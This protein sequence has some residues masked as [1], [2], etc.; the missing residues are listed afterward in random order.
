MI[1]ILRF[2][3]F[4]FLCFNSAYSQS[5]YFKT[6]KNFSNYVF[7]TSS[8][9]I[10]SS[11]VKLQTDSGSYYE[12]GAAIPFDNSRFSYEFGLSLNELNSIVEAPSNAVRYKTEFFGLNNSFNFSVIKSNR[13][14]WDAKLG[15]ELQSMVFG[16]QE[17]EGVLYDLKK[18]TEFN[19]LFFRQSF[20][21]QI[22]L[23]ATSQFN[24]SIGYDYYY[25]V[26][27]TKNSSNQS[28]LI[29]S[30]QVKFGIYYK[31]EKLKKDNKESLT[32]P[33]LESRDLNSS[34][35]ESMKDSEL[36]TI[37]S[38]NK[39]DIKQTSMPIRS[40]T[41][42]AIQNK[43]GVTQQNAV[44]NN[45]LKGSL[46][47]IN[48]SSR[49]TL[50][51]SDDNIVK[52]KRV[53]SSTGLKLAG[54]NTKANQSPMIVRPSSKSSVIPS[55]S[56]FV[57][58]INSNVSS[59]NFTSAPNSGDNIVKEKGVPL[60]TGLKLASTDT[61]S[62]SKSNDSSPLSKSS[63][64]T[65]KSSLVKPISSNVISNNPTPAK[66]ST[67]NLVEKSLSNSNSKI[68]K[69]LQNKPIS[70]TSKSDN[71]S[72]LSN[73]IKKTSNNTTSTSDVLSAILNRL[74]II[75]NKLNNLEKKYEDK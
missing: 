45:S 49:A 25:D 69:V 8:V 68:E 54:T 3:F 12:L 73:D 18:F 64:I 51:N 23:I 75:E 32:I 17:I 55:K 71:S 46:S 44:S 36:K 27:N 61:K 24:F 33:F 60:S 50:V 42:N 41:N 2:L 48:S 13:F 56:N 20:G 16:K 29:N 34:L 35:N 59:N 22:K 58:P 40:L 67:I 9:G 72:I 52:E 66:S 47:S 28:L 7:E 1:R 19:G 65:S 63:V 53:T 39:S 26:F 31:L 21:T 14:L 15:F 62:D 6:G 4:A 43:Q 37:K 74:S 5:F 10:Q 11:V 70:E 38:N 57:K 30:N